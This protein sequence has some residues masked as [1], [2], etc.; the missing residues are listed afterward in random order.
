M[1]TILFFLKS[2]LRNILKHRTAAR[3]RRL[4][5]H[6]RTIL[7]GNVSKEYFSTITVGKG[8]YGRLNVHFFGNS[9]EG[10]RIGNYVSIADNVTFILSGNH[11]TDTFSVYPTKSL[12]GRGISPDNDALSKGVIIIEDEVWIGT[13]VTVLSG[14]KIGMGA[15]VAA[16]SI[17]TKDV[18]PFA[19]VGGS[20]AR[21]IKWRIPQ[22]LHARRMNIRLADLSEEV[23]R[24]NMELFYRPLDEDTLSQ[25]ENLRR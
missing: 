7:E 3:W 11:R 16:G 19:I 12:I 9:Q 21:F 15:V 23:I 20:P 14:V 5:P 4:N 1:W 10:L 13:G 25:I 24:E 22:S 2:C 8:S 18:P 6:N 17:V